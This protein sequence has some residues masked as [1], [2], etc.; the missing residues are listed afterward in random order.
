MHVC[1]RDDATEVTV[2]STG[3]CYPIPNFGDH[4]T[5]ERI[6]D[7]EELLERHTFI[8]EGYQ[9]DRNVYIAK[10]IEHSNVTTVRYLNFGDQKGDVLKLWLIQELSTEGATH[11]IA[12]IHIKKNE[13]I[14]MLFEVYVKRGPGP[15]KA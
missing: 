11:A 12:K 13:E 2:H 3:V 14:R 8:N 4:L 9:F 15:Y 6:Y 10:I 7:A 5:G 1:G